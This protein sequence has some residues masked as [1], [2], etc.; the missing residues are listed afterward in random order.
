MA[1]CNIIQLF[2]SAP[3]YLRSSVHISSKINQVTEL[4]LIS[5][6]LLLFGWISQLGPSVFYSEDYYIV[7]KIELSQMSFS[8]LLLIQ[9]VS[10]PS[11]YKWHACPMSLLIFQQFNRQYE[12]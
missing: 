12:T 7:Q 1:L 2:H 9:A 10:T 8:L 4:P 6:P 3:F 11:L 5:K